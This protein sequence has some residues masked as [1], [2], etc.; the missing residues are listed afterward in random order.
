M[1]LPRHERAIV[2]R[3]KIV[4]YLLAHEDNSG[5]AGF[6]TRFG[7]TRS[8]WRVFAALMLRHVAQ[9]SCPCRKVHIWCKI[10]NRRANNNARRPQPAD[11]ICMDY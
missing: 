3:S 5:K 1:R 10:H 9:N 8:H 7:F 11:S 4:D 2:E 6:F